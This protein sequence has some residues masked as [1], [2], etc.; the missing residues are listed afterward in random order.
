MLPGVAG[1]HP[2]YC[3][4]HRSSRSQGSPALDIRQPRRHCGCLRRGIESQGNPCGGPC[5]SAANGLDCS[6]TWRQCGRPGRQQCAYLG[7]WTPMWAACPFVEQ[8][9][10]PGTGAW[11]PECLQCVHPGWPAP[12]PMR[13]LQHVWCDTE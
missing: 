10:A 13:W 1:H 8:L 7:Q 6:P 9:V 5:K 11:Q 3:S 4:W 12:G 2:A